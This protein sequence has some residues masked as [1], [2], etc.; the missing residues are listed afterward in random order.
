MPSKRYLTSTRRR[1][2]ARGRAPGWW[3]RNELGEV[4]TAPN[5]AVVQDLLTGLTVAEKRSLTVLRIKFAFNYR[6]AVDNTD[7][8]GA[9]GII[10]ME[11][12]AI[13]TASAVPDPVGDGDAKWSVYVHWNA[14]QEVNRNY[15]TINVNRKVSRRFGALG[16]RASF[17]LAMHNASTSNGSLEWSLH[18][19][20]Y[21]VEG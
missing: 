6:S 16:A 11:D 18:W 5:A 3:E 17:V 2:Q 10:R 21:V 7:V 8:H 15:R 14:L 20:L 9:L 12:E 13:A 19:E 1:G 4:T